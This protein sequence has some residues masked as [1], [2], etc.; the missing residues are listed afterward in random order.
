L[1]EKY[2]KYKDKKTEDK[3]EY[4]EKNMERNPINANP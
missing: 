2:S 3:N 1:K 4:P